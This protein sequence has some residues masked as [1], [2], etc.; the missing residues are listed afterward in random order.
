[1]KKPQEPPTS[2]ILEL[3]HDRT[4]EIVRQAARDLSLRQLSV[5]LICCSV[6][7]PQTVR[8]LAKYLHVP[9]ASISR[10]ADGLEQA[11]LAKRI[12][13][14]ADRRSVFITATPSGRRYC[15]RFFGS[16]RTS[17]TPSAPD[18]EAT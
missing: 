1:M 12:R 11:N 5:L 4:L 17:V 14:R 13:D 15:A 18:G 9:K 7:E 16:A 6:A 10:A 2:D 3:L 8:G